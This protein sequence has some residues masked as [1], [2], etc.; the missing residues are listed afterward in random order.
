MVV[1]RTVLHGL[2][3][4]VRWLPLAVSQAIAVLPEVER[5]KVRT[6]RG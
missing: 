6:R 2:L 5:R 1:Y 4:N 3:E